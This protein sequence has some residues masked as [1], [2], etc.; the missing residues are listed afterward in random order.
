MSD[1]ERLLGLV[2]IWKTACADFVTLARSIPDDQA[3][4]P[5]DLEG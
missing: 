1:R 4:L 5:T 3:H 2:E